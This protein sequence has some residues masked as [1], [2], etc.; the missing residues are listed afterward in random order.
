MLAAD[1]DRLIANAQHTA[2]SHEPSSAGTA[3]R[4]N[5]AGAGGVGWKVMRNSMGPSL[6]LPTAA[7]G[8]HGTERR[9]ESQQ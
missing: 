8:E 7:R 3:G 4:E 2:L 5:R 6:S 1:K 9:A